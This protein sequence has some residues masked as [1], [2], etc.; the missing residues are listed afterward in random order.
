MTDMVERVARA[1]WERRRESARSRGIML[2]AWGERGP[3]RGDVPILNDILGEAC[4]A[5]EAMREPT[6]AMVNAG[7]RLD[8]DLE[9]AEHDYAVPKIWGAMVDA[10]LKEP[11]RP[12]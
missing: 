5:I 1:I 10:A 4:A 6:E 7:C 12:A 3:F 8:E 11:D 9:W 2:E